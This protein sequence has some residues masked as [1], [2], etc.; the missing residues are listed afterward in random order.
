MN[1]SIPANRIPKLAALAAALGLCLPAFADIT[2]GISV[3]ATGPAASLGIPEKNTVALLP[4]TVAGQKVHYL[5]LDD[6]TNPT[7]ANK[8]ARKFASEDSAD[9]IFGSSTVPTSLAIAEVAAETK[10]PQ[11]ALAP[12]EIADAKKAWVFVVPQHNALMAKALA[13]HMKANGVKTLGFIGFADG[14]GEGWLKEMTRAAE[15]AGIKMVAVERYNRTDTSVTGQTVKLIAAK[16]DAILVAGSGT[17]AALPQIAL[18]DRGYKGKVYQTHGA[19]NKEFIRVGGKAVEGAVLP[20]GPVVVASQLPSSHPS[21]AVGMEYTKQY[22]EKYGAGTVSS[23]GAHLF[24][25]YRLFEAAVPNALKKGQPGTPAFRQALR[26]AIETDREVVG[27]H[28]VFNMSP[29][30]HYGHD[31]RARVLVK[32]ANGDWKLL[33]PGAK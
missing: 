32:I 20:V 11:I 26:D 29:T 28:G 15:A 7:E 1:R 17:P 33:E 21:K 3:S 22:E 8:N 27:A 4:T 18:V 16:P 9:I 10:T 30:D 24:D 25:A 14:Y 13:E 31:E 23:F 2:V 12:V 5:L 19:A 6:A